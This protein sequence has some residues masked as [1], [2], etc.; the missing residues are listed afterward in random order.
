MAKEKNSLGFLVLPVP[1]GEVSWGE[2]KDR[3]GID[4]H[5]IVEFYDD[6][7]N[8]L[9][10]LRLKN[11]VSKVILLED[12]FDIAKGAVPRVAV[13]GSFNYGAASDPDD[14]RSISFKVKHEG[15]QTLSLSIAALQ[16]EDT[17]EY[18]L[19]SGEFA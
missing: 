17:D 13:P 16:L 5:D 7:D 3:Y 2:Y 9:Y 6:T 18:R 1:N 19:V 14:T 4:I 8:D 11:S 15:G 12:T 10:Y